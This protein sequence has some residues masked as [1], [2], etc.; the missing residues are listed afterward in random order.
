MHHKIKIIISKVCTMR[1]EGKFI[2][3]Q[4]HRLKKVFQ[5]KI[6]QN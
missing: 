4:I 3:I 2:K 6:N 5:T 1:V